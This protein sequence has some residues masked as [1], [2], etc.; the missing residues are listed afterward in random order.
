MSH[1]LGPRSP[2]RT[3]KRAAHHHVRKALQELAPEARGADEAVHASRKHLKRARAALRLL[4]YGL[5]KKT[6][7]RE[8]RGLR[9]AG[10]RLSPARDAKV[11]LG[12]LREV[13]SDA[14]NRLKEM[15]EA[16][17]R[18]RRKVDFPKIRAALHKLERRARGW[19]PAD[20]GWAVVEQGIGRLY[21]DGHQ[22]YIDARSSPT[23]E[24]LHEWR[25]QIKY[26]G[27][28]L[29]L[30][31]PVAPR[32]LQPKVKQL[33]SAADVLG[34]DHDLATLSERSRRMLHGRRGGP[35][36]GAFA[37]RVAAKRAPLTRKA[38]E[39][40]KTMFADPPDAFSAS[41]HARRKTW[42]KQRR[43]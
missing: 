4:R 30:L 22:A 32:V 1:K 37:Q 33:S 12:L 34:V 14:R 23:A 9:D 36:E 31:S 40:G 39:L 26:L 27:A 28:A 7:K 8:N 29:D 25:K 42:M 41:F 3:I 24:R 20:G 5:D 19:D 43:K 11:L 21:A 10:R 13:R 6:Y 2:G 17:E 35:Y 15:I 38:L 18:E 16:L